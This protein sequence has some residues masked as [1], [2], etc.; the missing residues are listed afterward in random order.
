VLF[1]Q[2]PFPI[3]ELT[4]RCRSSLMNVPLL[5]PILFVPVAAVRNGLSAVNY[6][7]DDCVAFVARDPVAS[8]Y[9]PVSTKLMFG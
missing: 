3:I 1:V 8:C 9:V 5:A 4:M 6:V 7:K 2:S